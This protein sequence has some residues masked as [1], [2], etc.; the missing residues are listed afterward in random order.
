MNITFEE[1]LKNRLK[2]PTKYKEGIKLRYKLTKKDRK[3][4]SELT[5][6]KT[7]NKKRYERRRNMRR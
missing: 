4:L 3:M 1:Q 7:S 5:K 2:L 6:G